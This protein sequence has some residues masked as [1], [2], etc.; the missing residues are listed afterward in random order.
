V[1]K[2]ITAIAKAKT[3][4]VASSHVT[5]LKCLLL[6]QEINFLR[7]LELT[8]RTPLN[9]QI[10]QVFQAKTI[11]QISQIANSLLATYIQLAEL[12]KASLENKARLRQLAKT[13]RPQPSNCCAR[14][15]GCCYPGE[16]ED[17]VNNTIKAQRE[18]QVALDKEGELKQP[19]LPTRT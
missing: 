18:S 12:G 11:E 15:F 3:T 10:V 7:S 8:A 4:E 6:Q 2:Q 14:L 16:W 19:L 1:R 9:D 5:Q 17:A 13:L